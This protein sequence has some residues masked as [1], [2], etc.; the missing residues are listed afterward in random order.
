MLTSLGLDRKT[1]LVLSN[2]DTSVIKSASN[3]ANLDTA[4]WE[5]L[6]VY[7]IL[8]NKKIVFVKEA[9]EKVQEKYK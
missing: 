2:I 9:L 1:L 6:S 4:F 7:D 8:N 3:V 5:N